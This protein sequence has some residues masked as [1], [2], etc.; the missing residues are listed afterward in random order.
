MLPIE[1]LKQKVADQSERIA[2]LEQSN[3]TL[4]KLNEYLHED[5]AKH[6]FRENFVCEHFE[7][8]GDLSVYDLFEQGYNAWVAEKA[9]IKAD[10]A[11][12]K[13]DLKDARAFMERATRPL[14]SQS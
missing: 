10:E 12:D 4:E 8:K 1:V 11:Q 6:E 9:E 13:A 2:F 5:I 3:R 14:I 7:A